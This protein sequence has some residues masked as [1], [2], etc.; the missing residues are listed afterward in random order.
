MCAVDPSG[1]RRDDEIDT[2][3]EIAVSPEDDVE[4][5]RLSVTNRGDRAREIEVTSYVELA[6][7]AP[8]DDLAHPAAGKLFL[9]T[10]YLPASTALLCEKRPQLADEAGEWAVAGPGV[11]GPV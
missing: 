8:V 9:E 6:L 11:G 10:A 3:L 2:Q 4:V 7:A 5:R 1:R